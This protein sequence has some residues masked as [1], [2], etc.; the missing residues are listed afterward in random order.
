MSYALRAIEN[1]LK[2]LR[3][4]FVLYAVKSTPSSLNCSAK[5]VFR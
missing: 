3:Y 5:W 2:T 4:F 1:I